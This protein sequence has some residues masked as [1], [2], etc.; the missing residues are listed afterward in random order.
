VKIKLTTIDK[1][2]YIVGHPILPEL[3]VETAFHMFLQ[4]FKSAGYYVTVQGKEA[5]FFHSLMLA[6]V[7]AED[8]KPLVAAPKINLKKSV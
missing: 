2:Q 5:I 3:T 8:A 4:Q 6:E 1:K 7:V